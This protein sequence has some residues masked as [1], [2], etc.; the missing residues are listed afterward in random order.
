M[1]FGKTDQQRRDKLKQW[2]T[3]FAFIPC[4]LWDGRWIWLRSYVVRVSKSDHYGGPGVYVHGPFAQRF[5]SIPKQR[6][7]GPPPKLPK[8]TSVISQQKRPATPRKPETDFEI[9][10][11]EEQTATDR[12][13]VD[14]IRRSLTGEELDQSLWQQKADPAAQAHAHGMNAARHRKR[15][16]ILA[17]GAGLAIAAALLWRVL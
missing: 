2:R 14:A 11:P 9:V 3:R 1:I 16:R 8:A 5:L 17:I 15:L 12:A 4:Q 10:S 13:V 6:K 7:P